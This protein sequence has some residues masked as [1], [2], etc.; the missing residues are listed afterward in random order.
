MTCDERDRLTKK[1][2]SYPCLIIELQSINL[3]IS[4]HAIYEDVALSET[5]L[6]TNTKE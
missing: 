2:K 4:I 6:E 5:N 1:H 3:Q